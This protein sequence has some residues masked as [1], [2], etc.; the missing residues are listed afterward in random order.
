M[1]TIVALRVPSGQINVLVPTELPSTGT[2]DLTVQTPGGA[3]APQTLTPAPAAPGIF[4]YGDPLVPSRRH[5]VAVT[6]RTAW[7]AIPLS[8]A[9][10][11]GVPATCGSAAA[12]CAQPAR[13]GGYPQSYVTGLAKA[14]PNGEPNG[15]ALATG[16][17]A[18]ASGSP[19]KQTVAAPAVTIGGQPATVLFSGVAPGYNGL[20]RVDVQIPANIAAGD[21]VPPSQ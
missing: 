21:D 2:V 1:R 5:A 7:I 9:A 11:P 6:A 19:L 8:P 15:A 12:L 18:P 14:T 16:S 13:R 4:Y 20:Y 3:S 17:V 10:S